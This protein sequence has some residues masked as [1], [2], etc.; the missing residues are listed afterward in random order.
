M[1]VP[2][3]TVRCI[4]APAG[5]PDV[6]TDGQVEEYLSLL[7]SPDAIMIRSS[8][9]DEVAK[10][11]FGV[12]GMER[13][14]GSALKE[15]V[16]NSLQDS[17]QLQHTMQ[18]EFQDDASVA[19][20]LTA[21]GRTGNGTTGVIQDDFPAFVRFVLAY[22]I[23]CYFET[24]WLQSSRPPAPE[25]QRKPRVVFVLG[26]PGSGKGTQC[27]RISETYGYKHLSAGDLLREERSKAGSQYGDLIE[28]YIKD[29]KLVP[30]EITVKLIQQAMQTQGWAGGNFLIDGFPRSFDNWTGWQSVM[31]ATVDIKFALFFNVTE[32]CME[33]RL[34]ERG[35]TSGRSDDNAATIRKRFATFQQES[36]PMVEW[37]ATQSMLRKIGGELS[38]EDVWNNVQGAFAPS[39][40]FVLGGPGAGKGTIC[41]RIAETFG[42]RHLSAGDLLRAER[43][44]PGSELGALIEACIQEGKLVPAEITVRLLLEAMQQHGWEGGR[45]L[46]DGF[47][48]SSD[49]LQ[50]WRAEVKGRVAVKFCLYLE[51]SE[52]MMEARLL[53]RGK[54]S[55]RSDDNLTSI[56]KRF[57]V[58]HTESLPVVAHFRSQNMLKSINA[59][60]AV[61]K[62]WGDVQTLFG[63]AVVFV[64][65][66]PGSGKGT[67]CANIVERHG[68]KH[69]SAGDLLRDERKR[70]GSE[71]GELIESYIKEG[72]LVPVEITVKLIVKAIEQHGWEGGKYLID[73]F[74]RSLDNLDGWNQVV[75]SK[76]KVLF[77]LF[78]EC[79]EST[80]QARLLER[81]KTSGRTD[82]NLES[83]KKRFVT[84]TNESL[85]VLQLLEQQG[86]LR[87]IDA[88]QTGE[89]VWAH[90]QKLF[91]PTVIF[92]IG[93]PGAGKGTQCARISPSFGF[94]H[95]SIGDLLR[96]EC[97][98]QDSDC[99]EVIQ[100]HMKQGKLVPVSVV[101][102]ILHAAMDRRGWEGGQY[103]IDGFPR[104]FE[105]WR[106]WQEVLGSQVNVKCMICLDC[107]EPV[108]LDRL[109]TA[110]N[111]RD[112]AI[113]SIKKRFDI[114][115][116]E[117]LP[118]I[119]SFMQQGL[120]RKVNAE[121][122]SDDVWSCIQELMH[123]EL[124]VH[125]HNQAVVIVKPHAHNKDTDRFVQSYLTSKNI[126]ILDK[127]AISGAD[128]SSRNL[129]KR[130]YCHIIRHAEADPASL[131]LHTE[132]EVLFRETFGLE[133]SD[134]VAQGKLASAF[135]AVARLRMSH[136]ELFDAWNQASA[137]TLAP[138]VQ[139]ARIVGKQGH[140]CFVINGFVPHWQDTFSDCPEVLVFVVEFGK[141]HLSW[142]QFRSDIIGSTDPRQA[143]PGSIR[144][145]LLEHWREV[146]LTK[147]PDTLNNCIH[148]SAGPLEA[149]RERMLWVG[150]EL[151]GDP[152]ARNLL[153]SGIPRPM[154][155]A[156]LDNADVENWPVGS[157]ET[158]TGPLFD[159]TADCDSEQFCKAALFFAGRKS[160][161][162]L[163][164]W[165]MRARAKPFKPAV[166][167]GVD[168]ADATGVPAV[169]ATNGTKAPPQRMTILHFN[170]VYNVE[171]RVKEPVGGI[172][173]FVTRIRELKEESLA[174]G[175]EEAMVLFSGDA[176]NPSLTSTT[177]R[178][179]HM[180]PALN[181]I[182]IHTACYGNHD[183]DW[184]VDQLVHMAA[185]SNFP[186]LISNVIDKKTGRPLAEGAATRLV[187]WHGRKIGLLGL[188]ERE[189]LVTLATISPEDVEYE[190]FCHCAARLAKNL[191]EQ[192]GAEIVIAL[193]HMRVPNDELLAHEVAE[194]DIILGGHDH[195]YDV[196]P[197][198]PHGTYV[199]KSGTDFRD[200]TVFQLEFTK[201]AAKPFTVIDTTHVEIDSSIAEDPESKVFVDECMAKLG[202]SMD[203][204]LG[205]TACDLDS[206]FA[207]IR[208]QETNVGNFVTDVMRK[209]LNADLAVL[210]SGTLRADAII[211]K[212]PVKMRD[213]VNLL[214]MLDEVCLL[215]MTGAQILSVLENSVS[216]Y[217]RLEGRFAQVSGVTFTFDAAKPGGQRVVDGSVKIGE[218]VLDNS[219][220]Y[221]LCTKDYLR[222][223]KDGY[224]VFK[225][226]ICLAD[227]EQAGILPSLVR[228]YFQTIATLNGESDKASTMAT[229]R[230][231]V[232]AA[233]GLARVGDGP[234]PMQRWAIEPKI[235]A[236]IVCLNPV[237]VC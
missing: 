134:A 168:A 31:G 175:E 117:S 142:K 43:Q 229:S 87:R 121:Q 18:V 200:I 55:G 124:D 215:Q 177:T 42:Y 103:L 10:R 92:I 54:T 158:R 67:Q 89:E 214:P 19:H 187:D 147:Q 141:S 188:V 203:K 28:S 169:I 66:G 193:T 160:T 21:F 61:E 137:L 98:T 63:P 53:E 202:S 146:G 120:L 86:G 80:M 46:I 221:K 48:R 223:G 184:G 15:A 180:V 216:Q 107:S 51:C 133:W 34:M 115:R 126:A 213:L 163:D 205:E 2:M 220:S 199:L 162:A 192:Q 195:H 157:R 36:M 171:P 47:P 143:Y 209:A 76:A 174:R 227:G 93:G 71:Y 232:A 196:K 97:Q 201:G 25:D 14:H 78:F 127:I 236:R 152:L 118:V 17:E 102:Q 219:K 125:T 88:E 111:G 7:S 30:V 129:F 218:A 135:G 81:G 217:P 225:D 94:H 161:G 233:D 119:N 70:I 165:P 13:L 173:R 113:D 189:W 100:S 68:Y 65:G 104:S 224:D 29:G 170:D 159:C 204:V 153:A 138:S 166:A 90:V 176:F 5:S 208:T 228:E 185:Q 50:A 151:S 131:H 58:F 191:K 6:L 194:V 150:A 106:G 183:F 207:A 140:D 210:N 190:D 237:A 144:A 23:H 16:K 154:L 73:G 1:A 38:V 182:G 77:S 212:G 35:K 149:L 226:A 75:G 109:T 155:E 79:G 82:D 178:G 112:A 132:A 4:R 84:F 44:R 99:K 105:N 181:S 222:Q 9:F 20:A 186:W 64:L 172:A 52:G 128:F 62:V 167:A 69:L 12:M 22:R 85:P 136:Q 156:W 72:K 40:V 230:A 37:F 145:Q 114:Y 211:E 32:A 206:R 11:Q 83:I 123:N 110:H 74:P 60:Q 26:G 49:N 130:Q 41:S 197:V 234:E 59:E 24:S 148:A 56:R 39:V 101:L 45:Y 139:V 95:I 27:A 96:E 122:D 116:N 198:G 235:E 3:Q 57:V 164:C 179:E 91:T 108:M 33:A 8:A 231:S